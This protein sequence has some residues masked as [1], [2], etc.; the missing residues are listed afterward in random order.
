MYPCVI[1][2]CAAMAEKDH[3]ECAAHGAGYRVA[4][5]ASG[6]RCGNCRW[7]ISEGEW[8]RRGKDNGVKHV[9]ACRVHPDVE[10]ERKAQATT[11]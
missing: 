9:K 5:F 11:P 1:P 4:T 2:G 3:G 10:K 7:L 6:L 8:Y